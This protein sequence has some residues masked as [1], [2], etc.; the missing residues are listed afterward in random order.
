MGPRDGPTP[1]RSGRAGNA[2]APLDN[3]LGAL[4]SSA[5]AHHKTAAPAMI[6]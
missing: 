3:A 5:Q 1:Q 4:P 6:R 2:V